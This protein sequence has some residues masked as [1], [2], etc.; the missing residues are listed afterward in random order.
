VQWTLRGS[1]GDEGFARAFAAA[2]PALGGG[3]LLTAIEVEHNDGPWDNPDK[4]K[5]VNGVLRYSTGDTVNG[6][7]VT[8]MGYHAAWH[9]TDQIPSRAIKDGSS[10]ALSASARIERP[11]DTTSGALPPRRR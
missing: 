9:A 3:H 10:P 11:S 5:K 6:L 4:Y 2:S 8:A 1:H 7:A